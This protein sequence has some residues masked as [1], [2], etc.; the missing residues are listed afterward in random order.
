MTMQSETFRCPTC[1]A[2]MG[3]IIDGVF[4]RQRSGAVEVDGPT[5]QVR[6]TCHNSKPG[7]EHKGLLI[8]KGKDGVWRDIVE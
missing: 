8:I 7:Q 1:N 6:L 2:I 5:Y 4:Y 3:E